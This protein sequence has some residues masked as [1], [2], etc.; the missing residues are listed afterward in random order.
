MSDRIGGE[1]TVNG[2]RSGEGVLLPSR[3][4]AEYFHQFMH[5]LGGPKARPRIA[6]FAI[7]IF[8]I[9]IFT[10]IGQIRLNQW[11]GAFYNAVSKRD[12]PAFLTQLVVFGEVV[13]ALLALGVSQT[14]LHQ[15][16]KI[17][18]RETITQ[19]LLDE[20][21]KP[22]RAYRLSLAGEI[23]ANPD[24]RI[25]EDARRLAE[26]TADL[27]VGLV[28]SGLLLISF[29]GVLWGLSPKVTFV[30]GDASYM[31][32]GYMV[33]CAVGYALTG[34]WLASI[35][36]G[37]LIRRNAELRAREAELRFAL[38]RVSETSLG[39]A[40]YGGEAG[41]RAHLD[42]AL[43]T[44]V[45]TARGMANTITK[46]TTITAG[47]GWLAL[48][49]P[50]IVAS[51]GYFTNSMS[52]GDLMIIVGAFIQV[53]QSLR[54]YVD[55]FSNIAELRAM[56]E[57]IIAFRDALSGADA[58]GVECGQIK[59]EEHPQGG[60]TLE[61]LAVFAPHGRITA[62][63][64]LV[65][66]RPAGRL[67]IVGEA[68]S[69]KSTFFHALAG[70]WPWGTGSIRLPPRDQIMFL[71]H[72]PYM[73]LG[74]LRAALTYPAPPEQFSDETV[75][76]ALDRIGLSPLAPDLD[77]VA[78]WDQELPL[79]EQQRVAYVRVLLHKPRWVIQD[80]ALS[81]LDETTEELA[82]SIFATDLA[83]TGLISIGGE[84]D[85]EQFYDKTLRLKVDSPG[86]DLSALAAPCRPPG[87]QRQ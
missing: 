31:I 24:Q 13:L 63:G 57:R 41:E 39:V 81:E 7:A 73:P 58:L 15:T 11:Q 46:L 33:W 40:I 68:R 38:V 54:W 52:F 37:S 20:W 10:A 79:D 23:G 62:D 19:G 84:H 1:A 47:Y 71:P 12:F 16:L 8:V 70:L 34:S 60:A 30:Y 32:P 29:V 9:L 72:R 18:L 22:M 82:Y 26:L 85:H 55:N 66:I 27:G 64:Q 45:R 53:Q 51:P 25:H 69:G 6:A 74:S 2:G 83:G 50:I 35:V 77:R 67:R 86:L 59:Y 21:L 5:I 14:W 4:A 65:E 49:A 43:N 76:A 56:L 44:V 28:Q 17:R 87:H 48:V 78:R 80:E 3:S 75:R 61:G 42:T 36:G